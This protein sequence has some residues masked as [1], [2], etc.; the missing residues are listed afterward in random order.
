MPLQRSVKLRRRI[1]SKP[2]ILSTRYKIQ[3]ANPWL[4]NRNCL[5]TKS[6]P[7]LVKG[8]KDTFLW[9]ILLTKF[10]STVMPARYWD[11]LQLFN[12]H[13]LSSSNSSKVSWVWTSF[14]SLIKMGSLLAWI[15]QRSTSKSWTKSNNKSL[16]RTNWLKNKKRNVSKIKLMTTLKNRERSI[17]LCK[18]SFLIITDPCNKIWAFKSCLP[19]RIARM[20]SP[21]FRDKILWEIK[22]VLRPRMASRGANSV[23]KKISRWSWKYRNRARTKKRKITASPKLS[24]NRTQNYETSSLSLPKK[25]V[26]TVCT[27]LDHQTL[28]ILNLWI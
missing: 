26:V 27:L 2:R 12:K 4:S 21:N 20:T 15:M 5:R 24:V 7:T 14:N 11:R 10:D 19:R 13:L 23:K 9:R 16:I 28:E 25:R 8:A 6:T 22:E 3:K 17:V 1:T 18:N